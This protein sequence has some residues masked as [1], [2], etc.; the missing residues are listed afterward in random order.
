[1][2]PLD[3]AFWEGTL[4]IL[5]VPVIFLTIGVIGATWKVMVKPRLHKG[6]H[7]EA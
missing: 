6:R 2:S 1:M 7:E 4:T 5:A 3:H